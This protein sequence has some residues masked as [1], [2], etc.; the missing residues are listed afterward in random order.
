MNYADFLISSEKSELS[1]SSEPFAVDLIK[2]N[3]CSIVK[4]I[5]RNFTLLY[6]RNNSLM[7]ETVMNSLQLD[8]Q[9]KSTVSM[10]TKRIGDDDEMRTLCWLAFA[11]FSTLM[12][13]TESIII[14]H[15][16]QHLSKLALES[17]RVFTNARRPTNIV[18]SS[19]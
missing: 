8:K 14:K 4:L 13:E 7:K 5:D 10:N 16:E 17:Q 18:K 2:Q 1:L 3:E 15:C 19:S 6:T 11:L 12:N 9:K